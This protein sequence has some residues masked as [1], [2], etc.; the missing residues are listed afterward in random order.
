MSDYYSI[1]DAAKKLHAKLAD[2]LAG[3]LQA[4]LPSAW[5]DAAVDSLGR[6]FYDSAFSP[7]GHALGIH[8]P[9]P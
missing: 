8:R 6:R 1:G 4:F 7:S 3:P 5:I 2:Q 9:G